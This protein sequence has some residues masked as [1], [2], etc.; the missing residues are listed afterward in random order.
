VNPYFQVSATTLYWKP[1]TYQIISAG[2]D[3]VF[4]AG[5]V[6]WSANTA[7]QAVGTAGPLNQY[8]KPAGADDQANFNFSTLGGS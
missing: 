7:A 5:N 3:G 8:K 2:R 4:G 1:N 6:P